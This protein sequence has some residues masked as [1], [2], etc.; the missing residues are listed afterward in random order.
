MFDKYIGIDYTG[1]NAPVSQLPALQVFAATPLETPRQI[2]VPSA[3]AQNWSR[4]ELAMW[5]THELMANVRSIVAID[6]GFSFPIAYMRRNKL[7]SWGDFLTHFRRL[8]QTDRDHMYVDFARKTNPPTGASHELRLCEQWTES[9]EGVFRFGE[10]TAFAHSTHAGIV[11]LD[12]IRNHPGL[13]DKVHFWPFDGFDIPS[14]KSVVAESYPALFH[15]RFEGAE[16]GRDEHDAYSVSMWLKQMDRRGALPQY[17][18]PPLT[19]PERRIAEIEG[20]ILGVY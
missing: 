15:K 6:H 1:R 16:P 14:N 13:R 4:K 8:W 3:A 20:W 18:N 11:W 19:L 17:L 5:C 12:V 9:A 7:K 10:P 2:A